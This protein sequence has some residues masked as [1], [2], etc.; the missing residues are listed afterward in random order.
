VTATTLSSLTYCQKKSRTEIWHE[1]MEHPARL[2]VDTPPS[3]DGHCGLCGPVMH[4]TVEPFHHCET[5]GHAS[6]MYHSGSAL[7]MQRVDG[8][9]KHCL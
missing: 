1:G 9:Q 6:D 3:F 5:H 2:R 4:E 8:I 7:A